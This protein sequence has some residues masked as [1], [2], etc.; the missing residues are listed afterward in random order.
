MKWYGCA[1]LSIAVVVWTFSQACV[2]APKEISVDVGS[3]RPEPVDTGSVPPDYDQA[4]AELRKAH[5]EINYLRNK[6]AD[7]E[8]DKDELKEDKEE[9]ED[10]KDEYKKRYEKLKD[11]YED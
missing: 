8:K 7:L 11:K 1:G 5:R 6:V 2:Q 4:V 10:E 3:S 9:L